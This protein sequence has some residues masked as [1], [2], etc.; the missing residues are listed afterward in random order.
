MKIQICDFWRQRRTRIRN[1]TAAALFFLVL[2]YSTWILFGPEYTMSASFITVL[3]QTKRKQKQTPKSLCALFV[4]Q[5]GLSVLAFLACHHI[6]FCIVF[7]IL[8]PFLLVF[9]QSSQFEQLGYFASGMGFLFLQLRPVPWSA[10]GTYIGSVAY[11]MVLLLAVLLAGTYGKKDDG[12]EENL[13]KG[14]LLVADLFRQISGGGLDGTKRQELFEIQ[15]QLYINAYHSHGMNYRVTKKGKLNY[16]YALFFQRVLYYTAEMEKG[17]FLDCAKEELLMTADIL[18]RFA[19]EGHSFS[20]QDKMTGFLRGISDKEDKNT[21]VVVR[22]GSMF[23]LILKYEGNMDSVKGEEWRLPKHRKPLHRVLSCLKLDA[24]EFRFAARLSIILAGTLLFNMLSGVEHAYW[25]ALNAFLLLRP[26]YED[27][28]QRLKTRFLGTMLGCIFVSLA[29]PFVPSVAGHLA[30]GS[31]FSFFLYYSVPGTWQQALCATCFGLILASISLQMTLAVELRFGF[32]LVAVMLVFVVN[33][34]I[35][36]TSEKGIF[37]RNVMQMFYVQ[38]RYLRIMKRALYTQISYGF[39]CDALSHFYLIYQQME[40]YLEKQKEQDIQEFYK[41]MMSVFWEMQSSAEQILLFITSE[42]VEEEN[43][44]VLEHDICILDY[45]LQT[46]ENGV[47]KEKA[48]EVEEF[49]FRP[50]Q[51]EIKGERHLSFL[52]KKYSHTISVVYQMVLQEQKIRKKQKVKN[53]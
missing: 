14:L 23:L 28:S 11:G 43:R 35:F 42:E 20:L 9:L 12:E 4:Q 53:N 17:M 15:K 37:Q 13:K 52:L 3:F 19:K 45:V 38:H 32:V 47:R 22:I 49:E 27:S 2:F 24:F 16:F 36:R 46:A 39:T 25:L 18:E 48:K 44:K 34:F 7:N 10:F 21:A 29:M 8:V 30:V 33:R 6:A 40:Q 41:N 26:M 31:V 51:H 50:F 1:A 5:A